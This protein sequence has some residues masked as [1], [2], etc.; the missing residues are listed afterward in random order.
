MKTGNVTQCNVTHMWMVVGYIID[1]S[2]YAF[3]KNPRENIF[4]IVRKPLKKKQFPIQKKRASEIWQNNTRQNG[5]HLC[6]IVNYVG[7]DYFD[8]FQRKLREN[9]FDIVRKPAKT[10]FSHRKTPPSAMVPYAQY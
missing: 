6:V 3:Q 2:F 8:V 9:I 10:I 1:A 5:T 7:G 4:N